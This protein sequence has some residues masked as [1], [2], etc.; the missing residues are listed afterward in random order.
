MHH[1]H[2]SEPVK[3]MKRSLFSAAAFFFAASKSCIQPS[4]P[5]KEN[6]LEA[7]MV[8]A[9]IDAVFMV[10]S[11]RERGEDLIPCNLRDFLALFDAVH[12][13]PLDVGD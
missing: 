4:P 3:S 1:P 2:Q 9:I 8:D 12:L 5:A 13:T 6:K 11:L 10:M 7:I